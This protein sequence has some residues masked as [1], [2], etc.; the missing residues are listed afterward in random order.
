MPLKQQVKVN[1]GL[2]IPRE[3]LIKANIEEEVEMEFTNKEIRIHSVEKG[4][5]KSAA[6]VWQNTEGHWKNHPVFGNMKTNEIIEWIRGS[7]SDV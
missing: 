6:Q 5:K 1:T 7:D 3:L 4:V 2:F